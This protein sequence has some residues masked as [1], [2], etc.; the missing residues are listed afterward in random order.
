M[1]IFRQNDFSGGL[2]AQLDPAKSADNAFPLLINGRIRRNIVS[3]T[4]RHEALDG[5][6]GTYQGLYAAGN[7]LILFVSGVAYYADITEDPIVFQPVSG[8]T[9]MNASAERLYAEIV[10]A[11]SNFFNREGT[12]DV[13][14]RTFNGSIAAFSQALFV[15]DGL[16]QPQAV[17][18]NGNAVTLNTFAQWTQDNPEYVPIGT[19]PAIAG[20]KLFLVSPD[21]RRVFHSV[22]GRPHDFVVNIAA[23]GSAGGDAETVATAVSFNDITALKALSTGQVLVSTL[24]GTFVLDLDFEREIFGEPFLRPVFL[25]PTG[26]VNELSTVDILQDTAMITQSGIHAFNAVAQAKRESNNFPL[27]AKIRGLLVNPQSD[28]CATLFDDYAYFAVNTIHG[29]GA[30]VYDTISQSFQSLD[31]SFG[32]VKQFANTKIAGQERLFFITNDNRIFEAFAADEKNVARIYLGDWTPQTADGTVIVDRIG[33]VFTN[34]QSDGNCKLSI[35]RDHE[36]HES[37]I[38]QCVNPG[39]SLNLPIPVPF[40]SSP[41]TFDPEWAL[42]DVCRGWRVGVMLEWDFDGDLSDVSLD[43]KIDNGPDTQEPLKTL[44]EDQDHLAFFAESGYTNELNTGGDFPEDGYVSIAVSR[45]E[46]YVYL[47]NGNGVLVNGNQQI[48]DGIF[49]AKG[50]Y[51]AIRGNGTKTFTLRNAQDYCA[52]LSAIQSNSDITAILHGGNFSYPS[53]RLI[54]VLAALEPLRIPIHAIA[55]AIDQTT[56]NGLNFYAKLGVPRYYHREYTYVDVFF[57]NSD[58]SNPDGVDEDSV[59]AAA[60]RNWARASTKPFKFVVCPDAPYSNDEDVYPG[61]TDLRY[62]ASLGVTAVLSGG[63][64][65]MERFDVD[66]FPYFVVGSGGQ[67]LGDFEGATT[68]AFRDNESFGYLHIVADPVT[69]E[70]TFRDVDN[71]IL[72]TH[73]L[74]A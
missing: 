69:C 72:D 37:S 16:N 74:Y 31:L 12:A 3:P 70:L 68:S 58:A 35:F 65:V 57:F 36:L 47:S 32:R 6:D 45:G 49:T 59:Q 1:V 34:V 21:H 52:V 42:T 33:A 14:T 18:P 10:P 66:G 71:N 28:T 29:Y 13:V 64:K 4:N 19:L 62:F 41:Q 38:F 53:G 39:H 8:W 51:V 60:V 17:L 24:Q 23:D 46:K 2:D 26:A 63:G 9:T 73:A 54:D 22:T 25:F 30:L 67:T 40:V 61:R 20:N 50:D 56:D 7:Y 5:P 43:G 11:N 55:G 48:T 15:F 44:V 27:G